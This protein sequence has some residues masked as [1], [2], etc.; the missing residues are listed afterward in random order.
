MVWDLGVRF[1]PIAGMIWDSMGLCH[2]IVYSW[3]LPSHLSHPISLGVILGVILEVIL[4]N[5]LLDYRPM[6]WFLNRKILL[7][8]I[9]LPRILLFL[10]F[11]FAFAFAFSLHLKPHP[12]NPSRRPSYCSSSLSFFMCANKR[13]HV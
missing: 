7:E 5:I 4:E 12:A 13:I 1:H 8:R 6:D 11:S 10:S 2:G 9:G 3:N